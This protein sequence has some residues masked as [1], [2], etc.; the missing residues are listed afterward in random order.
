MVTVGLFESI[1]CENIVFVFDVFTEEHDEEKDRGV[2]TVEAQTDRHTRAREKSASNGA[3]RELE[4]ANT[5]RHV[6][7]RERHLRQ[8]KPP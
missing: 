8:E 4:K 5:L 2:E 6:H 3:R 1:L 7:Q